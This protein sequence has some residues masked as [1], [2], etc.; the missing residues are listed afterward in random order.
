[1]SLAGLVASMYQRKN[2]AIKPA[3]VKAKGV[4][5]SAFTARDKKRSAG[6][7][8]GFGRKSGRLA[9]IP[10][11]TPV[12]P[13]RSAA[14]SPARSGASRIRDFVGGVFRRLRGGAR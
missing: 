11:A 13:A 14:S 10:G 1:M 2:A 9:V 7:K 5:G 3:K 8:A 12:R 4:S 6:T